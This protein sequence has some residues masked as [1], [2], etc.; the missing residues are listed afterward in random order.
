M[1]IWIYHLFE[2]WKKL[3]VEFHKTYLNELWGLKYFKRTE[4]LTL[5]NI[6]RTESHIIQHLNAAI[7]PKMKIPEIPLRKQQK[8]K[9]V[10]APTKKKQKCI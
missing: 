1:F 3:S 7:S 9:I 6:N 4:S 5:Q 2:N 10:S 8:Y